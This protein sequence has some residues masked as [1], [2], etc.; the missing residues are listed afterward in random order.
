LPRPYTGGRL[1]LR[2]RMLRGVSRQATKFRL[3]GA[4]IPVLD[5]QDHFSSTGERKLY[6][7]M[8][9]APRP[10]SQDVACG[11]A[12]R[13]SSRH[14][15]PLAQGAA[16]TPP[17]PDPQNASE[18]DGVVG[19]TAAAIAAQ[20]AKL[21]QHFRCVLGVAVAEQD[22]ASRVDQRWRGLGMQRPKYNGPTGE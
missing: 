14:W 2:I 20:P 18:A 6:S 17:A 12:R 7:P 19:V 1:P 15:A 4:P 21:D 9:T 13:P 22:R 5:P 8:S 16:S 11:S 10:R 3:K